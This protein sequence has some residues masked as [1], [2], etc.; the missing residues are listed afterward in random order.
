MVKEH[1]EAL[2]IIWALVASIIGI[3]VGI[4]IGLRLDILQI[5]SINYV[6]IAVLSTIAIMM[7]I[8]RPTK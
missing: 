5:I 8:L 4:N 3:V 6:L 1:D 2:P 7:W